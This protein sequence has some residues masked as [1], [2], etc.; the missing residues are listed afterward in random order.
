MTGH[1]WGSQ[2]TSNICSG[3]PL[4]LL[5]F[6]QFLAKR[7][8]RQLVKEITNLANKRTWD[9]DLDQE[10]KEQFCLDNWH[11]S[12]Y[13]YIV[14]ISLLYSSRVSKP[15]APWAMSTCKTSKLREQLLFKTWISRQS[16][17]LASVKEFFIGKNRESFEFPNEKLCY[18]LPVANLLFELSHVIKR[19]LSSSTNQFSADIFF[20]S[21][22]TF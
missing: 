18:T 15:W 3:R 8:K 5:Q 7:T 2:H 21:Q 1:L 22:A 10:D 16:F 17:L 14:T 13:F 20:W 12:D 4:L 19:R 9:K 11:T 6:L